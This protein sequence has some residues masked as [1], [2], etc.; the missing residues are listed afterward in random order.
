[1][2]QFTDMYVA[3]GLN[4]LKMSMILELHLGIDHWM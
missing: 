4:E 3:S 1:M 2:T